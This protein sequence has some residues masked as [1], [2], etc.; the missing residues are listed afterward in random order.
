MWRSGDAS[1]VHARRPSKGFCAFS[2]HRRHRSQSSSARATA[3]RLRLDLCRSIVLFRPLASEDDHAAE[4]NIEGLRG[5]LASAT[6]R[7]GTLIG[8]G[9]FEKDMLALLALEPD[10]QALGGSA[11]QGARA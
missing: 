5:V 7:E 3:L 11:R 2:S 8:L 9:R 4:A 10:S 1:S 6:H